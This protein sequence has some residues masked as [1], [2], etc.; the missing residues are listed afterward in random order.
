MAKRRRSAI[1]MSDMQACRKCGELDDHFG[2]DHFDEEGF[3]I[4]VQCDHC[5][6]WID[7]RDIDEDGDCRRCGQAYRSRVRR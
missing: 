7:A 5:K 2:D 6:A 3:C 1:L 4:K